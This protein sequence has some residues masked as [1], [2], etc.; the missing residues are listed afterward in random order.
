MNKDT[1][2]VYLYVF[3]LSYS[4]KE[5]RCAIKTE[6]PLKVQF[7]LTL[8]GVGVQEWSKYQRYQKGT[9]AKSLYI[10]SQ[11]TIKGGGV[12]QKSPANVV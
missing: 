11:Q 4:D 10:Y 7:W 8:K 9:S 6:A 5:L 3:L 2:F 12:S 1:N